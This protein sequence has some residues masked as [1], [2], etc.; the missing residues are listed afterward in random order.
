[1]S[2]KKY[3]SSGKA[4]CPAKYHGVCLDHVIGFADITIVA[5]F[6]SRL[7]ITAGSGSGLI[8]LGLLK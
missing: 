2:R 8:F 4:G 5:N 7:R 3:K 1:M 6:S